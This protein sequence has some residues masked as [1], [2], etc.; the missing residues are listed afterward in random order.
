MFF[1]SRP[2]AGALLNAPI[3]PFLLEKVSNNSGIKD[4][5]RKRDELEEEKEETIK[6]LEEAAEFFK[7]LWESKAPEENPDPDGVSPSSGQRRLGHLLESLG[8]LKSKASGADFE[9]SL[10]KLKDV[11]VWQVFNRLVDELDGFPLYVK[12]QDPQDADGMRGALTLASQAAQTNAPQTLL[13]AGRTGLQ[14]P[15]QEGR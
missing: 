11:T 6:A 2:D 14:H 13:R 10:N 7:G 15:H 12:G 8:L 4:I 5:I 9:Y 3:G 1:V